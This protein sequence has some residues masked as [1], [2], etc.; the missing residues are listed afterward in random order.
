ML[1]QNDYFENSLQKVHAVFTSLT[2]YNA[3][4]LEMKTKPVWKFNLVETKSKNKKCPQ[5]LDKKIQKIASTITGI[6]SLE[7]Q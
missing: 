7:A 3:N 1:F 2:E 4:L 6:K 5:I